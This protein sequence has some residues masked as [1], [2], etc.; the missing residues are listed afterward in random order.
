MRIWKWTLQVCDTQTL[1]MPEGAQVLSVQVQGGM[2]QL[3]ALIDETKPQVSRTFSTYGTGYPLPR[4]LGPGQHRK[5]AFIGT[6]L[7]EDGGLVLHVFENPIQII[8]LPYTG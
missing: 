2:P 1:S 7:M 5:H 6:Y 3:W 8:P 4:S